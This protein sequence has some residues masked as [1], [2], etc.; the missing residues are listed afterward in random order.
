LPVGEATDPSMPSGPSRDVVPVAAFQAGPRPES[1]EEPPISGSS[2]GIANLAR[3]QAGPIPDSSQ[4]RSPG[5][6]PGLQ[7]GGPQGQV[8]QRAPG[9]SSSVAP[10][11]A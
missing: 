6:V 5:S 8:P 3:G 1:L 4:Q 10:L 7:I 9:S 2:P 11:V